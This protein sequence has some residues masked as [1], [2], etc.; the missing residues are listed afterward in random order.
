M[1]VGM[2]SV[3]SSFAVYTILMRVGMN[4]VRL[5]APILPISQLSSFAE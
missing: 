1:L 2:T 4:S 5:C 3:V